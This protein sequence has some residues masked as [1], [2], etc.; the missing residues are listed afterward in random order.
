MLAAYSI[1][2]DKKELNEIVNRQHLDEEVLKK[3]VDYL[4]PG[5]VKQHLLEWH[6]APSER[7]LDVANGYQKRFEARLAG[8]KA[9][10]DE[11]RVQ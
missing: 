11:W 8:W 7:M 9:K 3:W 4:K 5:K 2:H 1:Y 6:R 10:N